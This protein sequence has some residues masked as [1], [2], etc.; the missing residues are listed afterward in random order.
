MVNGERADSFSPCIADCHL[1]V[2]TTFAVVKALLVFH[3]MGSCLDLSLPRPVP[4]STCPC[5]DLSLP[6]PV[7]ASTCPC[8][9]LSLPRPVPAS[10]CPCLDLSLPRPVPAST[11]P[12]L[13]LSLPRPVPASCGVDLHQH[14][15]GRITLIERVQQHC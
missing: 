2:G 13:D 9:D 7:P 14:K 6:R 5:L 15:D 8:L 10:T 1:G 12:C 11:C 3:N 4:A